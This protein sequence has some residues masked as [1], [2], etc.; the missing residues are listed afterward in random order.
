MSTQQHIKKGNLRPF[1]EKGHTAL[2][3]AQSNSTYGKFSRTDSRTPWV[4]QIENVFGLF[5]QTFSFY[6]LEATDFISANQNNHAEYLTMYSVDPG[7]VCNVILMLANSCPGQQF[8]LNDTVYDT[9]KDGDWFLWGSNVSFELVNNSN[10]LIHALFLTGQTVYS[11]QLNDL[12]CFNVP[13]VPESVKTSHPVMQSVILTKIVDK[14]VPFMLYMDNGSIDQLND[15]N[16][17]DDSRDVINAKGLSIYLYEPMCS[18]LESSTPRYE[19]AS[20]H[21]NGFYSEFDNNV[22]PAELR[23]DE[24]NS[25]FEYACRNNLTNVTVNTGDYDVSA[26]YP[27]YT[28]ILNLVTNDLF[29]TCQSRIDDLLPIPTYNFTKKF[30]CLNW[31]YTK[32]R[33]LLSTFLCQMPVHLSWYFKSSFDILAQDLFFDLEHWKVT[34]SSLYDQLKINTDYINKNGPFYVDEPATDA[35]II[36][37]PYFLEM[38][39]K[40]NQYNN[41]VT[42]ALF[43]STATKLSDYYSDIFV[44]IVNETRFAQPTGNFSEK[45]FQSM[46]YL[47]PFILV[48]PPKTLEYVKTFGYRTFDE[49]WDESYD[50]EMDHG[51]RMA[52]IFEVIEYI[53]NKTIDELREIYV[54]MIPILEHNLKIFKEQH[55]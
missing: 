34:H 26:W 47:K 43:N 25:I 40:V 39:P 29:L 2:Q 37:H 7:I 55:E 9:W 18:F 45:V 11:G 3:Y 24:L 49:F 53:N 14:T 51:E 31:R 44:D 19:F 12:F 35:V 8:S 36:E 21:T 20:K 41:G 22:T 13:G 52:K 16:H 42:P 48:A 38:W 27:H 50:N 10:E 33:H 32:H 28:P 15:I 4:Q 6:K 54:Q 30:M 1:W 5:K 46:Q 23:S 17:D